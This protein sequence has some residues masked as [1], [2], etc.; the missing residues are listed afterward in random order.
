MS[1]GQALDLLDDN[2]RRNA[3]I[4]LAVA[5]VLIIALLVVPLPA[6]LLDLSLAGVIGISIVV[7]LVALQTTN[8]LDFSS[9][10]ALLLLLTLFRLALN[11]SS[12]RLILTEG[13]AGAVIQSFGE[14]VVGG[15]FAVGLV[16]FVIL[17]GINFIVITKGAGRVAEVAARFTLDAMP[18]K[19]M[20]IDA[21]L[22]A[23][24]ID[25]DEARKRRQTLESESA[26]FGNM[27]GASKFVRGDAIAGLIITF[28]NIIAGMIIG[29]MQEG[30]SLAEA[31]NIYTLL[32]VGDGLV[33]QVP[34]LIVSTAA[35]ILVSK[36]GVRGSAD[37][38]LVEQFTTYPRA[39]GMSAA[40]MGLMAI[41]PGMPMVP[42]LALS[43]GAGWLA[44]NA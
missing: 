23:G 9:F 39:L 8:P 41:L 12:T 21:D 10:P 26:F 7:L 25:E 24:L 34:A 28:I 43:G 13:H 35:G 30:L 40:V 19:Q 11:V 17:V 2:R 42:F 1:A 22:S 14:F 18:G 16:I 44:F 6:V 20:A 37:K 27:D 5:V 4:G 31:G 38:A 32:T 33:S 36:A 15:N 3:E 29:M